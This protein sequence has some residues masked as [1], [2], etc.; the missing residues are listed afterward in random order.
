[1][2]GQIGCKG[3]ATSLLVTQVHGNRISS[4]KASP[5]SP[6]ARPLPDFKQWK[7]LLGTRNGCTQLRASLRD[8][9]RSPVPIEPEID[10]DLHS[11]LNMASDEELE[12]LYSGLYGELL[13]AQYFK[14]ILL[15][16][17]HK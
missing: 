7:S 5:V 17:N 13:L 6:F 2:Q 12:D 1:M 14:A 10:E 8:P 15:L 11:V 9:P 3:I 16:S 4:P